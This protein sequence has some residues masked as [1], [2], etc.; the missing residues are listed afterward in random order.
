MGSQDDEDEDIDAMSMV[1]FRPH[2]FATNFLV[3]EL[4]LFR[5]KRAGALL[6]RV[7]AEVMVKC[8]RREMMCD[9]CL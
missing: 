4:Q 3:N 7:E 8:E 5:R 1:E 6:M 9:V 2:P